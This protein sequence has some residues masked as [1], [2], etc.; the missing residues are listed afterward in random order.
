MAVGNLAFSNRTAVLAHVN[1]GDFEP[2]LAIQGRHRLDVAMRAIQ[3]E[4]RA[5]IGY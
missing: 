2:A 1:A 4:V 3:F 5:D